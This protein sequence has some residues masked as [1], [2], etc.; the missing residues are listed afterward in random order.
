MI[1]REASGCRLFLLDWVADP[2]YANQIDAFLQVSHFARFTPNP[3]RNMAGSRGGLLRA[4]TGTEPE[5]CRQHDTRQLRGRVRQRRGGA[6]VLVLADFSDDVPAQNDAVLSRSSAG[7]RAVSQHH[8]GN[9]ANAARVM[10][11]ASERGEVGE[12]RVL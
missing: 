8:A 10:E 12:G 5:R 3:G 6:L 11:A 7:F 4:S 9:I 2:S 1:A